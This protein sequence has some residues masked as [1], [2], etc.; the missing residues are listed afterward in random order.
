MTIRFGVA[1]TA[2]WAR[3]VHVP[4]LMALPE[5]ELVGVW[6]RSS[7]KVQTVSGAY[8]IRGFATFDEMLA[9]VDAVSIAVP[10]DAQAG[11]AVAA[12]RLG[13]HLLLEKP[14]STSVEG[15]RAVLSSANAK[16][17]AVVFFMR[18]F[19]SDIED[20]IADVAKKKWESAEVRVHSSA[21]SADGPYSGS[22]WRKVEGAALWD[23]APHVLSILIPALGAVTRVEASHGADRV[24][25][26]TTHH[27]RGTIANSSL[28]LHSHLATPVR[29]Y[30]F[31]DNGERRTLP[32]PD[33][34]HQAALTR[35]ASDLITMINTADFRHR[36]GVAFG[37]E[38][39][40]IL[41]AAARSARTRSAVDV[42]VFSAS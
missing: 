24:T 14:L 33:F 8:G 6:G 9:N 2:H 10:P 21:M 42:P 27:T 16:V 19:V 38:I 11:L 20:A 39:V 34:S 1:G 41:D 23:I 29:E 28:T 12:A 7:E 26:L 18:R 3:H 15:A 5:V 32:E 30:V 40:E 22:D 25:H 37:A 4:G 13:K 36:C 17:A 31:I 35:A